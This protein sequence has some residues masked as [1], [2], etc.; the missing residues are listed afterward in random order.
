MADIREWIKGISFF[1][2]V[3]LLFY[4]FWTNIFSNII[5]FV[6]TDI[7][8]IGDSTE[9]AILKGMVWASFVILYLSVGSIYLVY[10]IIGGSKGD[11]KTRPLEFLKAIGI[12]VVLM[13]FLTF[14][15]GL[16]YYMQTSLASATSTVLDNT[17][18]TTAST[19]TWVFALLILVT[20]VVVPFIYVI[21]GYGVELF[22]GGEKT[23]GE[24]QGV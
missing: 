7:F 12:W 24:V 9:I 1:V 3:T 21:K 8:N 23:G 13:P 20:L 14:I 2:F 19:F 17:S 15:Y 18:L 16:V 22:G 11:I 10:S 6:G 4:Y 5:A